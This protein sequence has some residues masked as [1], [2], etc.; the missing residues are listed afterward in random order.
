MVPP[1]TNNMYRINPILPNGTS[2]SVSDDSES[3]R[4]CCCCHTG[5]RY[6]IL[7]I[8]ALCLTSI[9]SNMIT[10]NFTLILMR[11]TNWE[12]ASFPD[13]SKDLLQPNAVPLKVSNLHKNIYLSGI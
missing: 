1:T 10:Y 11:R 7:L 4:C 12:N 5:F 3:C 8:A 6:G 2:K 9:S 13:N